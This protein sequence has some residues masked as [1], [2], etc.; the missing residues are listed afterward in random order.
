[1]H[2]VVLLRGRVSDLCFDAASWSLED[3]QNESHIETNRLG[4]RIWEYFE[5]DSFLDSSFCLSSECLRS[6]I[7]YATP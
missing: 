6:L 5:L 7:T 1:M 4:L 3:R 2:K